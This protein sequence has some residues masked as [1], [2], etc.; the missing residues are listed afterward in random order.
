MIRHVSFDFDGVLANS[1]ETNLTYIH[2][3]LVNVGVNLDPEIEYA[4]ILELWGKS[5]KALME[6]LLQEHPEKVNEALAHINKAR[7]STEYHH[8]IPL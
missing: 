8:D 5:A 3:T 6:N 7:A 4:R 2:R 1:N